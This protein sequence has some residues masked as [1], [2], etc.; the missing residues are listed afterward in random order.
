MAQKDLDTGS[1]HHGATVEQ[2]SL[3]KRLADGRCVVIPTDQRDFFAVDLLP[4]FVGTFGAEVTDD[5]QAVPFRDD[6]R[7]DTAEHFGIVLNCALISASQ[8]YTRRIEM[9]ISYKM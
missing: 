9:G 1:H 6:A 5:V 7:I 4:P 8:G 2:V 3:A